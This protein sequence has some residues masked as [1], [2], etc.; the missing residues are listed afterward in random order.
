M[1]FNFETISYKNSSAHEPV[2]ENMPHF[3]RFIAKND[4]KFLNKSKPLTSFL[5]MKRNK[6]GKFFSAKVRAH[7]SSNSQ[8]FQNWNSLI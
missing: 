7:S 4:V 6:C 3:L 2:S 8:S 5:V 1:N